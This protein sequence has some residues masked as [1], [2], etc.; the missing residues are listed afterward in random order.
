M[1]FFGFDTSL[2]KDKNSGNKGIFEHKDPFAG[3]Q[4]TRKLQAFQ[5]NNEE[6]ESVNFRAFQKLRNSNLGPD[7]TLT[8]PMMAWPTSSKRPGMI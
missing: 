1:S 2:P 6:E 4:Q 7:S 8:T 3:I 5:D